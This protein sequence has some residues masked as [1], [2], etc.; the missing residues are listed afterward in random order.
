MT[1]PTRRERARAET[2]REIRERAHA[3]LVDR[4]RDAVTLRAIARELGITAPALYRYY[5][6]REEL[7]RGV[8]DDIC[9]DL[10]A[11]LS[12]SIDAVPDHDAVC[13]LYAV[14]RGFRNW[15]LAHPEEFALV[16]ATPEVREVPGEAGAVGEGAH[17]QFAR[18][19]LGVAGWLVAERQLR[20]L[21]DDAVPAE[22][23]AGL[24]AFRQEILQIFAET[25]VPVDAESLTVGTTY[26][27]LRGWARLLGQVALEVF[28]QL[29]FALTNTEPLF[30]SVLV[31][32]AEDLGLTPRSRPSALCIHTLPTSQ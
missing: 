32:L 27:L 15:A 26:L 20:R 30:E 31:E 13:R 17:G 10:A 23:H 24:T 29:Q 18:V 12:R 11:E 25:R 16:F 4:G 28:G 3:L 21:P 2:E 5:A 22:L 9:T 1:Q 7:L 6:S 8:C 19:F 14:C